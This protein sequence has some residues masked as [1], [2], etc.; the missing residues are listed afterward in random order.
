MFSEFYTKQSF[1]WT[2]LFHTVHIHGLGG[3]NSA[4][5]LRH[6]RS[7]AYSA[8]QALLNKQQIWCG[9]DCLHCYLYLT[10][11]WTSRTVSG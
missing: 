10:R 3:G 8:E 6:P 2:C 4:D 1:I 7:D 9:R 11:R 5:K